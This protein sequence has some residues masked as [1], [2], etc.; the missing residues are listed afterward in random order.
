[1]R[2]HLGRDRAGNVAVETALLLPVLLLMLGGLLDYGVMTYQSMALESAARAGA[3]YLLTH[4][5]DTEGARSVVAG[6]SALDAATLSI[7]PAELCECAGT[8]VGC[9]QSCAGGSAPRRYQKMTA[10]QPYKPLLPY[11]WVVRKPVVLQGEAILRV[12]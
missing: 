6:A 4:P 3:G 5:H 7:V 2:P 11:D 8:P 1:M 10:T 12:Q 9:S